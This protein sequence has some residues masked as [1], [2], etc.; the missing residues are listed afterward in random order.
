MYLTIYAQN[1]Q[2]FF[3]QVREQMVAERAEALNEQEERLTAMVT[4]MQLEKAQEVR[5]DF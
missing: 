1:V 5:K 3:I 2:M 4:K